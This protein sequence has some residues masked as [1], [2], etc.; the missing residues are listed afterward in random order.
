SLL[1]GRYIPIIALLLLADSMANK[2]PVPETPGTLRTD[3]PL[4][5]SV[6]A[7]VMLI[8]GLLTFFP[9]IALGPLAEAFQLGGY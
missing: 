6:T 2:Q 3:T 9:V 7:G 5:T 1:A 4:F 8:L